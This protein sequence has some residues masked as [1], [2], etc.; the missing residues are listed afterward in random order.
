MHFSPV[1][2]ACLLLTSLLAPALA[3]ADQSGLQGRLVELLE[4]MEGER[5]GAVVGLVRGGELVA[6]HAVGRADLSFGASFTL[7]TPTNI[8]STAKQFTGYALA[9]LHEQDRLSL[10]DDI[11]D[12]FPELP[13]FGETVT[14]RHLATHTSGYREFLNALAMAGVRIEKGD[15]IEPEE[16]IALIKRQPQLQN[17]PGAEWNYNNTGYVLLAKVIEQVTETPFADWLAQAVF[18]PLNMTSTRVRPDPTFVLGEA[19]RGYIKDGDQWREARDLGGAPGAGAVYT[20]LADMARWMVELEGFAHG[21]SRVGEMLTE[22]FEGTTYGLGL[23][24][25]DWRGQRRWQHGGGDLGHLSAFYYY[26]DLNAGVMVFANHH[27]LP[28]GLSTELTELLIGDALPTRQAVAVP[29]DPG[30]AFEDAYFDAFV[31][32]YE[33]ESAPGFVLRFFRDGEAYMTQAT[34]QPALSMTPDSARSFRIDGV[35]ARVVFD[36]PENGASPALTLFQNGEHRAQRLPEPEAGDDAEPFDDAD[37]DRFVGRYELK[38]MPGFVLR[39][40]RDDDRYMAQATG[41]P[42][43]EL[44]PV[45]ARSFSIDMVNA[46]I[47]FDVAEDGSAPSLTLF[48]NGEHRAVRLEDEDGPAPPDPA[49]FV[50]RYF[51]AELETFY[52]VAVEDDELVLRHRRFGPVTLRHKQDDA[53]QAV[54]PLATVDF[55][56]DEDG[57]VSGLK[58]GNLRTRDVW[59]ERV[60]SPGP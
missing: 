3:A 13:D 15:W 45:D 24:I 49:D 22:R 7:D 30:A 34:G 14:L 11:R 10:D 56:R 12:Y 23:I 51:S 8:G 48:Q 1:F 9:L 32:R 54:F 37:F 19:A 42:A 31:G 40:F 60:D 29:T 18:E 39:F 27:E 46:R 25:E 16:A 43:F 58:A 2:S 35:D 53:Y 6:A 41:Q 47:V 20:T 33:L 26:P 44:T 28:P 59:F 57:A 21:G 50:G 17:S 36:V 5:P 52:E 4:P 55:V 38:A